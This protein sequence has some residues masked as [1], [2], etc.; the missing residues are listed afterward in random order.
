MA[1]LT[2]RCLAFVACAAAACSWAEPEATPPE[3]PFAFAVLADP[4]IT[5]DAAREARLA[6]LV[7]WLNVEA[8]SRRIELVLVV[9]D[10]GWREGVETAR[11]LLGALEVPW[12]PLLGDNEVVY[13]SEDAFE[14]VFG[15]QLEALGSVVGGLRRA[16]RPVRLAVPDRD[17]SLQNFGF[18]W[19]GVRFVGLDW[20]SRQEGNVASEMGELHDVPGGS[21]EWLAG[22][23]SGHPEARGFVLASHIP[24]HGVLFDAR[25]MQAVATALEPRRTDILV[26]V[27]GHMH[28]NYEDVV[29]PLYDVWV[30]AA[31]WSHTKAIRI[32][33]IEPERDG[34]GV[35]QELVDVAF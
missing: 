28:L 33:R 11:A 30:T 6:Q 16:P 17:A 20:A 15:P 24:M 25:E 18:T 23:I 12:V 2:P 19:R 35:S 13:G 29:A 27:A 34:I 7:R 1:P 8:P 31:T 3:P 9:G 32:V 14:Q 10:L 21:L 4:H 5:T 22:E 26:N